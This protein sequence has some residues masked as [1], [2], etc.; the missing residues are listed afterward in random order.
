M[1]RRVKKV[2][3]LVKLTGN[4]KTR[5]WLKYGKTRNKNQPAPN[6]GEELKPK[7]QGGGAGPK[8]DN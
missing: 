7:R 1:T 5:E 2:D 8:D 3:N 4:A 6:R